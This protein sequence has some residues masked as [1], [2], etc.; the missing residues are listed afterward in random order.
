MMKERMIHRPR[1]LETL[2]LQREEIRGGF[3]Y[4][5]LYLQFEFWISEES[6]T[7]I[8]CTTQGNGCC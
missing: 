3:S 6:K 5:I 2:K 8:S 4:S 7:Y 1:K